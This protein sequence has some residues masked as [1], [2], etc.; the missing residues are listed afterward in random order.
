V[1]KALIT[2]ALTVLLPVVLFAGQHS[3]TDTE[4]ACDSAKSQQEM[5]QCYGEQFKKADAHLN[6]VYRRVL[7]FM[8]DNL[9][10]AQR[11]AATDEVKNY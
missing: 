10:D 3:T 11:R 8:H 4:R 6:V 5:N 1:K 7:G 9:S 2:A